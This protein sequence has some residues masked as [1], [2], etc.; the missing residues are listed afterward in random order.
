MI[1][2][3]EMNQRAEGFG[4]LYKCAM[5]F[6]AYCENNDDCEY[7]FRGFKDIGH[8]LNCTELT[9]FCGIP[10]NNDKVTIYKKQRRILN[11]A[12][13]LNTNSINKI[14]KYYYSNPKPKVDT[15]IA[16]H[17]RRG[18]VTPT[19]AVGR[20]FE[21]NY[22][23]EI[24][25]KLK[26]KYPNRI[27]SIFSQGNP[28]MFDE[29]KSENIKFELDKDIQYTFHSMVRANVLVIGCSAFSDAAAY[30]NENK[31]YYTNFTGVPKNLY[32]GFKLSHWQKIN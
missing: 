7:V 15:D 29:L 13:Y 16:I 1:K 24:I 18:D 25:N 23:L 12:Q 27:I 32:A 6:I 8:N 20:F 28:E 2:Y 3:Y 30:L 19:H 17:I 26:K 22:Y 11:M 4:T 9:K 31:I 10:I 14:K 5:S 21:L